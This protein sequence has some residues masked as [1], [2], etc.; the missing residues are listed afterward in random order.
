ADSTTDIVDALVSKGVLT[1]E[2][3]KLITKGHESKKEKTLEGK[4]KDGFVIE[5]SDGSNSMKIGGRLH[6]DYRNFSNKVSDTNTL[7]GTSKETSTFDVRRARLELSG[8]Y[9]KYYDYLLSADIAG[10]TNGLNS[11]SSSKDINILD[12]A[13]VNFKW[14]PKLQIR[15]G[16]MKSP[17]NLE[18]MTSSNN[19]DFQERSFVNQLAANEDRG[20]MVHGVPVT[21]TTYAIGFMSG[22]GAKGRN[23]NYP[24]VD[25]LEYIGRGT[26]NFAQLMDNKEAVMHLGGSY[27]YTNFDKQDTTANDQSNGWLSGSYKLRTQDRGVEFLALPAITGNIAGVSNEVERQRLGVEAVGAYG[28]FKVQ[29]EWIRNSFKTDLSST[30]KL[31]ADIDAYYV[32]ALY[33]ITGEKYSD[34]YKDGIFGGIKPKSEFNPDTGS[35]YGAWEIGA[36]YSKIDAGDFQ[37]YYGSAGTNIAAI[38]TTTN[39]LKA[40]TWTAGLKWVPNNNTRILLN[41]ART[42][43]DTPI[44]INGSAR[45]NEQAITTRVQFMF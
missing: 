37:P 45:D 14:I 25:E 2:E 1:E 38:T 34:F 31:D 15:V 39:T 42:S 29:G 11:S 24:K 17:M 9:R 16:Q 41:Y 20:I 44:T 10:A 6:M 18:K 4:F 13:W 23:D 12:Q 33:M 35:G 28:P 3:G 7:S 5:N 40:D 43:F 36:R 22:S 26:V 30:V 32:E 21:G 8:T 19:I 27:S